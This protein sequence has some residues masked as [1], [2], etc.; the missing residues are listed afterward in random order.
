MDVIVYNKCHH[1]FI[2]DSRHWEAMTHSACVVERSNTIK[3]R[4]RF[5]SPIIYWIFHTVRLMLLSEYWFACYTS[6]SSQNLK[7]YFLNDQHFTLPHIIASIK[8]LP[9]GGQREIKS[10]LLRWKGGLIILWPW[11]ITRCEFGL[12]LLI[13]RTA[14]WWYGMGGRISIFFSMMMCVKLPVSILDSSHVCG[15]TGVLHFQ[16]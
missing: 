2:S 5:L 12:W 4:W 10:L 16:T 15:V 14:R 8:E 11:F 7:W 3:L 9:G 1:Y 13:C 6:A